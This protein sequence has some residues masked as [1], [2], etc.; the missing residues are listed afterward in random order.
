MA[1]RES[2]ESHSLYLQ[3][4]TPPFMKGTRCDEWLYQLSHDTPDFAHNMVIIDP[5]MAVLFPLLRNRT[6]LILD[7]I[8]EVDR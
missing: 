7:I 8:N 5:V 4:G 6:P 3:A 1:A 2:V